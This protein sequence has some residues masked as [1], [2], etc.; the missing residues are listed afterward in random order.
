MKTRPSE[1]IDDPVHL[2]LREIREVEILSREGKG[3]IAKRIEAGRNAVCHGLYKFPLTFE[4]FRGWRDQL[5]N[6]EI[7]LRELV[8][9]RAT[10]FHDHVPSE[11][12]KNISVN[13]DEVKN[14][15]Y[16]SDDD[17]SGVSPSIIAMENDLK[18][19][20]IQKLDR[21]VDKN[22]QLQKVHSRIVDQYVS[23]KG[24]SPDDSIEVKNINKS[25]LRILKT[26]FINPQRINQ[27]VEQLHAANKALLKMERGIIR[28]AERHGIG[29]K[30]FDEQISG[31]EFN[32]FWKENIK[33]LSITWRNFVESE[34]NK[35]DEF[36]LS[37]EKF[38]RRLCLPLNEF[39]EYY[40]I[41]RNGDRQARMAMDDMIEAYQHSVVSIAK[42]YLNNG[43][44]LLDLVQEGNIGLVT[45]ID[46]FDFRRGTN[47]SIYATWWIR[48]SITRSID[49]Q[50]RMIRIPVHM[51][52]RIDKL[53]KTQKQYLRDEGREPTHLE[54]AKA[55]NQ[56]VDKIRKMLKFARYQISLN[57]LY[58][59]QERLM[60]DEENVRTEHL[61]FE[62]LWQDD[63]AAYPD[64]TI[65]QR[66]L[67]SAMT[68]VLSGLTPREEKILRLRFGIGPSM[69]EHTLEE[70]GKEFTVTRERIRQIEAKALRKL[71]HPA[72]NR[73][74]KTFL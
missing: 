53:E 64:E 71:N 40:R 28:S 3:S 50:A 74:L 68:S 55:L 67:S 44:P 47:F 34:G 8:D 2:Y 7:P 54:L 29:R 59:Y 57:D 63:Q 9:I 39:Q 18:P 26:M 12:L 10:H 51:I 17:S 38:C 4:A 16:E 60:E 48:Q 35:I 52:E 49:N 11:P 20:V 56:P 30:Q 70:V 19:G 5:I 65:I 41:M 32:S 46:R 1:R 6:N 45:A 24:V 33:D 73:A 14:D 69:E 15:N 43:L 66:K 27:L 62:D 58:L 22:D 42:R 13:H 23:G 61:S 21:I 25:I 37:L 36:Q 31:N 72:R